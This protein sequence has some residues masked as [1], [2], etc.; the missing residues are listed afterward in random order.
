MSTRLPPHVF[1]IASLVSP[2]GSIKPCTGE[3]RWE[4]EEGITFDITSEDHS[5]ARMLTA[6][7]K[8]EPGVGTFAD[9]PSS[10]SLILSL[11]DGKTAELF[12]INEPCN[13]TACHA[14]N[15]GCRWQL[16]GRATCAAIEIPRQNQFALWHQTNEVDRLC[17]FGL[18]IHAWPIETDI[19]YADIRGTHHVCRA[20]LSLSASPETALY[21]SP[22]CV[23]AFWLAHSGGDDTRSMW[24]HDACEQARAFL[25]FLA[26]RRIQICW[27]DTF[28]SSDYLRR[29]YFG[30]PRFVR[31]TSGIEQPLPLGTTIESFTYSAEV[32]QA[33]PAMFARFIELR[34][35]FAVD[36]VASPLWQAYEGIFDDRV[37]LACVSLERFATACHGYQERTSVAKVSNALLNLEQTEALR[38][39][40]KPILLSVG[41]T[42]GISEEVVCILSKKLDN[43]HQTTNADKLQSAFE[44]LGIKLLPEERRVLQLRN[45]CFHGRATLLDANDSEQVDT[46]GRRFDTLRTL[47]HRGILTILGY[48]GPFVDYSARPSSGNFPIR[49]LAGSQAN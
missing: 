7:R 28:V 49:R 3:I 36:W 12:G 6:D 24:I 41:A 13:T 1:H 29:L 16:S 34:D 2:D 21:S 47:I 32:V 37:A 18:D 22:D 35:T 43:L 10:P 30:W 46:E 14:L 42:C 4:I 48:Q 25:S 23:S 17:L 15:E 26:G 9:L 20:S 38:D 45:I 5:I 31:E 44:D 8:S 39:A 11:S 33:I 40:L 27:K 19:E